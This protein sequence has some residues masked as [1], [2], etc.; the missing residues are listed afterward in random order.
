[1]QL[2]DLTVDV[3]LARISSI[4]R[5][6]NIQTILAKQTLHILMPRCQQAACVE[7]AYHHLCMGYT[8][9]RSGGRHLSTVQ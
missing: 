2:P 1:M 7:P 4:S 3:I 5:R 8:S 6:L 9:L